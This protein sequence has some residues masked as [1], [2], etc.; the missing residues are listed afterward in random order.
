M[1]ISQEAKLDA[2]RLRAEAGLPPTIEDPAALGQLQ[3]LHRS[4]KRRS[5]S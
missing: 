4:V 1:I 5:D 3:D 2:I